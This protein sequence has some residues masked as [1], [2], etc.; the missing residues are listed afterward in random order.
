MYK[1]IL[2]IMLFT[3]VI[4]MCVNAYHTEKKTWKAA[5]DECG[6]DGLEFDE[7]VLTSI[8]V[9]YD[10]EFWIGM[11]IYHVTTPWIEILV[12]S[13]NVS[14]NDNGKC[15]ILSCVGGN[16]RLTATDCNDDNMQR[17][18]RC[19]NGSLLG[20]GRPYSTSRQ[21]CMSIY[22]LL[23]PPETYCKLD[24]HEN[25]AVFSW[26]NVFRAETEAKLSQAE[27]GTKRP[28]YCLAGSFTQNND[29]IELNIT[30]KVCFDQLQYF[31][32]RTGDEFTS[33][34]SQNTLATRK[35]KKGSNASFDIGAVIGGTLGA[36]SLI[37]VLVVLIVCKVGS[38]GIF[39]DSNTHNYE[40]T[41]RVNFSTSTYEDL[42]NTKHTN[43]SATTNQTCVIDEASTPVYEE[44]NK[45]EKPGNTI[46]K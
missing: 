42:G 5:S 11:A 9:L 25:E 39:T 40:D 1:I 14:E 30:R 36:C 33:T 35:I 10:K 43:L 20:W 28:L 8:D 13:G 45:I 44:V 19:N 3:F 27:A 16:N 29:K 46:S 2:W 23:L 32:C 41:S 26:T 12:F 4:D 17:A 7:K 15:T 24:G 21:R 6:R 34:K 22:Q 18:G 31:V 37:I 38:K